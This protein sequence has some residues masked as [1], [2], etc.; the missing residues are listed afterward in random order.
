MSEQLHPTEERVLIAIAR[1]WGERGIA[2]T[3]RELG[4]LV[5]MRS[6]SAV[7]YWLRELAEGGLIHW[8]TGS[9]RTVRLTPRGIEHIQITQEALS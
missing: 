2:P 4:E 9:A 5:G 1:Y 7:H 3:V 8:D 6:T